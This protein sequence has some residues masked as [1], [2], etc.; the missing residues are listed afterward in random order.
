LVLTKRKANF[1]GSVMQ[2]T[3]KNSTQ[4]KKK[5]SKKGVSPS[6]K[7]PIRNKQK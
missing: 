3:K 6:P 5:A 1:V 4:K 7:K 2:K